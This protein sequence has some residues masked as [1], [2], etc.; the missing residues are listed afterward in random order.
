MACNNFPLDSQAEIADHWVVSGETK[1][2]PAQKKIMAHLE[3]CPEYY[4]PNLAMEVAA[5]KLVRAGVLVKS[6]A[7]GDPVYWKSEERA[8]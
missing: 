5:N 4:P 6:E 3:T 8:K 2:T 7:H 1:M